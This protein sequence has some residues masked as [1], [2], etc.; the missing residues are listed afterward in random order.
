MLSWWIVVVVS[1]T[2]VSYIFMVYGIIEC[3]HESAVYASD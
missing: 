2:A 3:S 1:K